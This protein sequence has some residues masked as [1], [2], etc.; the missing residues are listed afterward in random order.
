MNVVFTIQ[1]STGSGSGSGGSGSERKMNEPLQKAFVAEALKRGMVGVEGH[2]S[3]GGMRVSLY[4]AISVEETESLAT[5]MKSFEA[6]H[7]AKQNDSK[8]TTK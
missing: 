7:W 2:R 3:V 4:N 5:L 1:T 8:P 6:E